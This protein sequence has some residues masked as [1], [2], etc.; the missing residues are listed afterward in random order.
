MYSMLGGDVNVL[1]TKSVLENVQTKA[2]EQLQRGRGRP[3]KYMVSHNT[4]NVAKKKLRRFGGKE[5]HALTLS[6]QYFTKKGQRKRLPFIVEYF[7]CELESA[8]IAETILKRRQI[9][10][11]K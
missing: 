3:K 7:F 2:D 8:T 6:L 9:L 1:Q 11:R 10:K 5:N 4:I